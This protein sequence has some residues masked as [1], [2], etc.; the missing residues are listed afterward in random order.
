MALVDQTKTWLSQYNLLPARRTAERTAFLY[1]VLLANLVLGFVVTKLNSAWLSLDEF[2]IYSFVVNTILFTGVFLSVGVFESGAMIFAGSPEKALE[3]SIL[4]AI[5]LITFGLGILLALLVYSYSYFFDDIFKIKISAILAVIW[6]LV[7]ITPFQVMVLP[8]LRGLS[9]I[10]R[11]G[12]FTISPR[13][14]YLLSLLILYFFGLYN[15]DSAL[16]FFFITMSVAGLIAVFFL[17]PSFAGLKTGLNKI[18]YEQ[19]TY[20]IH[21]YIANVF[22]ALVQH[23]D[24]IILAFFVN[25][26]QLAYY[27]LAF[28][29][30]F[31]LAHFPIALS[32]VSFKKYASQEKLNKRHVQVTMLFSIVSVVILI[33]LRE[34]IIIDLFGEKFRPAIQPFIILAIAFA[35]NGISIPYTMFFKAH[36]KGIHVRNITTTAQTLF[37]I[38]NLILIP[39]LGIMGAAIAAVLSFSVDLILYFIFHIRLFSKQ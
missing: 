27:A 25:S 32:N 2:G 18:F 29:L 3:K 11:L 13:I 19:K 35:I 28:A 5:T 9:R 20:G 38:L 23:T 6:P 22:T 31:P 36:K 16:S 33:L 24:K 37:L 30:T 1:A 17:K 34:F 12:I 4:G 15:L 39:Y 10:L 14:L 7:L 8:A 21:I 26:E